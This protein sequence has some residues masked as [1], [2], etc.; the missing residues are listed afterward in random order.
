MYRTE[1]VL[2]TLGMVRQHKLDV[3][4]GAA[5]AGDRERLISAKEGAH[6]ATRAVQCATPASL[7]AQPSP[8]AQTRWRP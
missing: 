8:G 3:V 4:L 1:D 2:S 7:R 5:T 6:C